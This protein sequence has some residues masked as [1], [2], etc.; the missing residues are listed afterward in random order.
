M[1]L[2]QSRGQSCIGSER[3]MSDIDWQYRQTARGNM[4]LA[5]QRQG[6]IGVNVLER[7]VLRAWG[8]RWQQLDAHNDDAVD[9]LIFL[10]KGGEMTGQVIFAQVKCHQTCLRADGNRAVKIKARQLQRNMRAWR[11]VVGA[12]V[13]VLVDPGTLEAW[14]VDLRKPAGMTKT[15]ILVPDDQRFEGSAKK[16]IGLLCGNIHRDLLAKSIVTTADD[17]KHV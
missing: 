6:Q 17:F 12:A 9:G 8:S 1:A 13:L 3:L 2:R 15:Q 5:K 11:C 10:E 16:D 4:S 7:I 14:W